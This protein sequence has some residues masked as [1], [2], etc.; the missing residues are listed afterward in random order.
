MIA[1]PTAL[2]AQPSPTSHNDN[3][4]AVTGAVERRDFDLR[5]DLQSH[6]HRPA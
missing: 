6:D 4:Q 5:P 1:T 2:F 3:P